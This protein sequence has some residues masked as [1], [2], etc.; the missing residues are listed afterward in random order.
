MMASTTI[1][2][3]LASIAAA[4]AVIVDAIT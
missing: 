3:A 4:A 1:P 2:F